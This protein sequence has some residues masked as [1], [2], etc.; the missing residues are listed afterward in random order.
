M[1]ECLFTKLAA[2]NRDRVLTDPDQYAPD[3][4]KLIATVSTTAAVT[5]RHSQC[6]VVTPVGTEGT[7][8]VAI[9]AN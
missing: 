6:P 7:N 9:I 8:T 5:T 2:N 3:R 4:L 1:N